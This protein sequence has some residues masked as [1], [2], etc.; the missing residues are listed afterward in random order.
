MK[1]KDIYKSI[2]K[3]MPPPQKVI[4]S[5]CSKGRKYNKSDRKWNK[6]TETYD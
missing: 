4:E 2:R 3:R 5:K 6:E 1:N